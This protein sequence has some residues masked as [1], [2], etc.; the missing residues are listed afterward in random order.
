MH[1]ANAGGR[2]ALLFAGAESLDD[3]SL[4]AIVLGHGAA[5]RSARRVAADLLAL[6]GGMHGLGRLEPAALRRVPGVGPGQTAR[7]LAALEVGRRATAVPLDPGTP[8]RSSRDVVAA[9]RP[10]LVDAREERFYAVPVDARHRPLRVVEVARGGLASCPVSP[11]DV[12]RQVLGAAAAA[13]V[14]V[15]NHPSGAPSPSREDQAFTTRMVRAGALLGIEVLDHVIVGREGD[16]SFL[17]A[18]W[19]PPAPGAG[20]G[21]EGV[22]SA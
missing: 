2:E 9:F 4:L 14:L 7:I 11:A 8:I 21:D 12:F 16:F 5:G 18:G 20:D 17:D 15:H 1:M 10:R 3:G 13:V 22:G 6:A 19:L